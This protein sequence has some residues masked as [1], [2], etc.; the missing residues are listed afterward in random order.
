MM[1]Q[2]GAQESRPE[3][4]ESFVAWTV[5]RELRDANAKIANQ[6]DLLMKAIEKDP[7]LDKAMTI[8]MGIRPKIPPQMGKLGGPTL[9]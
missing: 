8:T 1:D 3:F 9:P 4:N 7:S 5:L 2:I 6:A